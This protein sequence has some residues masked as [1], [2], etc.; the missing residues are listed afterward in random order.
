M[1][2]LDPDEE[3]WAEPKHLGDFTMFGSELTSAVGSS[4]G[5]W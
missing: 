2:P 5:H 3:I 1:L 4:F